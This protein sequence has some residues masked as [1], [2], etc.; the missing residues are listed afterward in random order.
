M[1][2]YLLGDTNSEYSPLLANIFLAFVFNESSKPNMEE[3]H[4]KFMKNTLQVILYQ[5]YPNTLFLIWSARLEA[6]FQ[7][8]TFDDYLET[9]MFA[10]L[11]GSPKKIAGVIISMLSN[12]LQETIAALPTK[13]NV[14]QEIEQKKIK[15]EVQLGKIQSDIKQQQQYLTHQK[16]ATKW[17]V[18][19]G[20]IET[21]TNPKF[22]DDDS[23]P[24]LKNLF[25]ANVSRTDL[26]NL[27]AKLLQKTLFIAKVGE[28]PVLFQ[29]KLCFPADSF[30]RKIDDPELTKQHIIPS[31]TSLFLNSRKQ[32]ENF[33]TISKV[34]TD[35]VGSQDLNILKNTTCEGSIRQKIG[36]L[37]KE[38]AKIILAIEKEDKKCQDK[39]AK[40]AQINENKILQPL[41]KAKNLADL[42]G[43]ICP[44]LPIAFATRCDCEVKPEIFEIIKGQILELAKQN[45]AGNNVGFTELSYTQIII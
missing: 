38:Q 42:F 16:T 44:I 17:D 40:L 6:P 11:Y 9:L 24:S 8:R 7:K 25:T 1:L 27:P 2:T 26:K 12:I 31:L 29:G 28:D 10:V 45:L 3:Q 36:G 22:G 43:F 19:V 14:A 39:I 23:S 21:S 35:F 13:E 5:Q 33:Q 34:V 32:Q 37:E 15:L 20:L 41:Q 18:H 30:Y 4:I